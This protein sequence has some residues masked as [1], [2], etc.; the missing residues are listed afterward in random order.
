VAGRGAEDAARP[1]VVAGPYTGTPP[2]VAAPGDW[3]GDGL[4]DWVAGTSGA[5]EGATGAGALRFLSGAPLADGVLADA[6]GS[7]FGDQEGAGLGA[8]CTAADVDGDGEREIVAYRAIDEDPGWLIVDAPG[9]LPAGAWEPEAVILM[10]SADTDL[11]SDRDAPHVGDL[12]GDGDDELLWRDYADRVEGELGGYAVV[13]GWD[14]PWPGATL[15][16]R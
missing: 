5:D 10:R 11:L 8:S 9:S 13:L 2:C 12:D 1:D 6:P 4:A 7:L 14:L 15:P 3:D 16:L